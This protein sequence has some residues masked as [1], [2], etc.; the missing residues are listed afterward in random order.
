MKNKH[1]IRLDGVD[2]MRERGTV[3]D[4]DLVLIFDT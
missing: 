4:R 3:G 2:E 1:E